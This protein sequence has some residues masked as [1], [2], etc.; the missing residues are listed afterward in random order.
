MTWLAAYTST[1]TTEV[2]SIF[3]GLK[4]KAPRTIYEGQGFR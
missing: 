2:K 1:P 4:Q 3:L